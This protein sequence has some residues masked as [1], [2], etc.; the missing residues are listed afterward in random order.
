MAPSIRTGELVVLEVKKG[1]STG[2]R[3]RF[4]RDLRGYVDR[5]QFGKYEYDR[6]GLLTEIPHVSLTRGVI[7]VAHED[8]PRLVRFL[9]RW[10]SVQ[11]RVVQLT[12]RDESV[13]FS[14]ARRPGRKRADRRSSKKKR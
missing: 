7:I 4:F 10:A 13:L 12:S 14:K 6:D 1:L 2:Q 8:A 3:R 9:R 11:T 5:S